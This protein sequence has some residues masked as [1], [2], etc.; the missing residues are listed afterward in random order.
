MKSLK[1]VSNLK[2]KYHPL[3]SEAEIRA[4]Q[5]EYMNSEDNKKLNK[6]PMHHLGN[7]S[8]PIIITYGNSNELKYLVILS[9]ANQ[10]I[11]PRRIMIKLLSI[12]AKEWWDNKA[13]YQMLGIEAI[14]LLNYCAYKNNLTIAGIHDVNRI[15]YID[16]AKLPEK[17]KTIEE[18]IVMR[19]KYGHDNMTKY[20]C[21]QCG[22][23]FILGDHAATILS[24][25]QPACPYCGSADMEWRAKVMHDE[26]S[27]IGDMAIHSLQENKK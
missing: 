21:I 16:I 10:V 26:I 8:D 20:E 3:M 27:E 2:K 11:R 18:I 14:Q 9:E 25:N 19:S 1:T 23:Q 17:E 22:G 24:D 6:I 5:V 13:F 4:M 7:E 12:Y 15:H